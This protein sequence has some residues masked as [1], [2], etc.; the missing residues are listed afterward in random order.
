[1]KK[2]RVN[3]NSFFEAFFKIVQKALKTTPALLLPSYKMRNG[4]RCTRNSRHHCSLR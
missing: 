1:M 4:Q 3:E 2:F